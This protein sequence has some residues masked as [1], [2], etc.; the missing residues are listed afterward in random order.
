[1]ILRDFGQYLA[2]EAASLDR[3]FAAGAEIEVDSADLV[4]WGL[5]GTSAIYAGPVADA[6]KRGAQISI[7]ARG[8]AAIPVMGMLN[9]RF[10]YGSFMSSYINIAFAVTAA[11]RDPKI[12]TI[13]LKIDS[14]GGYV[15]G[16][17]DASDAINRARASKPII[18]QI[19]DMGASAAYDLA[20]Q[21]STV[22]ANRPAMV[23]S[24][25]TLG[26]IY[27]FSKYLE[28][29]GIKAEV[30]ATGKYKWTGVEGTSLTEDQR[31]YIQSEVD[32]MGD[33]FVANVARG[34]RRSVQDIQKLATGRT[35]FADEAKKLGLIDDVR[36]YESTVSELGT[37]VAAAAARAERNRHLQL[38]AARL[39]QKQA[40]K[41]TQRA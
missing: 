36:N 32:R 3:W 24:I 26:V 25:G 27:D 33:D 23:G 1:M 8:V 14:P 28:K 10:G 17:A 20:S 31:K 5:A 7:P 15:H 11:A 18:A 22:Y 4:D 9:K 39:A 12:S 19:D 16:L 6:I 2:M 30:F 38:A 21:A 35:W 29:I 34:R 37:N 40:Q 41:S 13:L